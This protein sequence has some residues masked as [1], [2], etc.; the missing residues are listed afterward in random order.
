MD[1]LLAGKDSSLSEGLAPAAMSSA[2]RLWETFRGK[3]NSIPGPPEN[4]SASARI[5]VRL[6]P[7]ILFGINAESCSASPRNRVRLAPDSAISGKTRW[8]DVFVKRNGRWQVVASQGTMMP[9]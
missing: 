5:P 2:A 6:Q 9:K 3:P 7:G 8:T 4:R 1:V